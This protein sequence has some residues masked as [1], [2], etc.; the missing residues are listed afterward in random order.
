ME[1]DRPLGSYAALMGVFGALFGGLLLV[2]RDRLPR[3]FR[4]GDLVLGGIATHKISRLL[5]KDKVTQPLRAPFTKN[6]EEA[7]PSEVSEE[8]AGSGPR[9]AIGE[10]VSCPYCLGM[11]VGS[12]FLYGL[13]LAPRVTRFVAS[14][15]TVHALADFLQIGYSKG[16]DA[17]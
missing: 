7:G 4:F 5:A 16:Q 17:L 8:P 1:N 6:P 12:A 9:L 14:V 15:F 11:W 10:L 3:R 2:S 13:A